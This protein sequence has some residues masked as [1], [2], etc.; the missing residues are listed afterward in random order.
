MC[1]LACDVT[2]IHVFSP[3]NLS[4]D[5]RRA[6]AAALKD[7]AEPDRA[8]AAAGAAGP[9]LGLALDPVPAEQLPARPGPS[10]GTAAETE[11]PTR[12][13]GSRSGWRAAG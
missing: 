12:S 10:A 4:S 6:G 1:L 9:D 8:G 5:L 13:G 7:S 2:L 3:V 11:L